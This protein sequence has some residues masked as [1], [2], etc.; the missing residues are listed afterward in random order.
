V[1]GD[2]VAPPAQEAGEVCGVALQAA[3]VGSRMPWRT[4]AMTAILS[5]GVRTVVVSPCSG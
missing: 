2:P 3:G 4:D 5:G 1:D